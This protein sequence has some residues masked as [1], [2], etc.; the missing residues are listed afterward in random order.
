MSRITKEDV[1]MLV[2]SEL[3]ATDFKSEMVGNTLTI[4]DEISLES[5]GIDITKDSIDIN[6]FAT[7]FSG[8]IYDGIVHGCLQTG[9]R[10]NIYTAHG[11]ETYIDGELYEP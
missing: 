11:V 1:E 6:D 7:N 8:E 5:I 9:M 4:T 10:V 3:G 2:L